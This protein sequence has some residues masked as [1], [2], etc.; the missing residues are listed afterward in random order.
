VA[1][2][3]ASI[4]FE[5]KQIAT[6][7]NEHYSKLTQQTRRAAARVAILTGSPFSNVN[8]LN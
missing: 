6:Y 4:Q 8:K 5:F 1:Q 2:G 7:Q 3:T